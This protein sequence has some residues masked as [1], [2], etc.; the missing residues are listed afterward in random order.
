MSAYVAHIADSPISLDRIVL[1]LAAAAEE[2]PASNLGKDGTIIG[3]T[4][5]GDAVKLTTLTQ[6]FSTRSLRWPRPVI[7]ED[8]SAGNLQFLTIR[9][10]IPLARISSGQSTRAIAHDYFSQFFEL[11]ELRA[12]IV[13]ANQTNADHTIEILDG[14]PYQRSLIHQPVPIPTLDGSNRLAFCQ[15]FDRSVE[16][17]RTIDALE[18]SYGYP[19]NRI[20]SMATIFLKL[21]CEG[22]CGALTREDAIHLELFGRAKMSILQQNAETTRAELLT[23]TAE[24]RYNRTHGHWQIRT[25]D[26]RTLMVTSNLAKEVIVSDFGAKPENVIAMQHANAYR[27]PLEGNHAP[28]NV[29]RW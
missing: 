11:S 22:R 17:S 26:G 3:I 1:Y 12:N 9:T 10:E 5:Q 29:E 6:H 13:A 4:V 18:R 20:A 28:R 23:F 15:L 14:D 19:K 24:R 7:L 21:L 8:H 16:G 25:T 27:I 2:I